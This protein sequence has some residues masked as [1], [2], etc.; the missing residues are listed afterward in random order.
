MRPIR[1][2]PLLR[3]LWPAA[4]RQ[5]MAIWMPT[6][7][8]VPSPW[9][10]SPWR[11]VIA[12]I[13]AVFATVAAAQDTAPDIAIAAAMNQQGLLEFCE[14]SG[15][16]GSEPART[17]ARVIATFPPPQNAAMVED[18]YRKGQTGTVSA[19]QME[20]PLSEAAAAQGTTAAAICAELAQAAEQAALQLPQQ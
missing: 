3:G 18:A 13:G 19:M 4:R 8:Q 6:R 9:K 15:H 16:I 2:Q 12:M 7:F 14:A 5:S 10:S 20:Q 1:L 17:Q 11:T